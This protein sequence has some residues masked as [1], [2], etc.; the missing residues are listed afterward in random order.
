MKK[1]KRNIGLILSMAFLL[2]ACSGSE[3][4]SGK[5][6]NIVTVSTTGMIADA[7]SNIV[8]EKA[9]V[10]SLMG[11][12]VDPHLYK[13]TQGDLEKLQKADIIFYNGLHLEGKMAEVLEKLAQ[14]KKVIPVS[15]GISADKLRLL[16]KEGT[17]IDP[18]IWFNVALWKEAVLYASAE[19]QKLDT[20]NKSLYQSNTIRYA[21]ELDSLDNWV[22][23]EI[24]TIPQQSRLLITAHDAFGYFG[25]AYKIEVK[26]LQGISTVSDYG[27]NDVTSLVNLIVSRKIKAVFIETSVSDK[28]I[29]AVVEGC[30]SKGHDVKIGGALYSDAMGKAGTPDGTYI[31]MVKANVNTI[32]KSL[33]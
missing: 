5:S 21:A 28:S 11:A 33:K 9:A 4:D 32:V 18:H 27:L 29:R 14:K 3:K 15:N 1:I 30:R 17:I 10:T 24:N 19:L 23:T 16:T 26:G 25:D 20:L 13:V 22:K 12:G 31:G 8:G 2:V 7:L 6:L